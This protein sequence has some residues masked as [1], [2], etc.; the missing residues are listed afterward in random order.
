M[1][2]VISQCRPLP[3]LLALQLGEHT[4]PN[5]G[6]QAL[7]HAPPGALRLPGPGVTMEAVGAA[8]TSRFERVAEALARKQQSGPRF[9]AD[10]IAAFLVKEMSYGN[11]SLDWLRRLDGFP[12]KDCRL[13][14][15]YATRTMKPEIQYSAFHRILALCAVYPDLAQEFRNSQYLSEFKTKDTVFSAWDRSEDPACDYRWHFICELAAAALTDDVIPSLVHRRSRDELCFGVIEGTTV[16]EHLLNISATADATMSSHLA[17]R[18]LCTILA[19]P[20]FWA[21]LE[22]PF[23]RHHQDKRDQSRQHVIAR[24]FDRAKLLLQDAGF[25]EALDI[26]VPSTAPIPVDEEAID[27]FCMVLLDGFASYLRTHLPLHGMEAMMKHEVWYGGLNCV[28]QLL[29]WYLQSSPASDQRLTISR[30]EKFAACLVKP[31]CRWSASC[32]VRSIL[33]LTLKESWW[34]KLGDPVL[35]HFALYSVS[36]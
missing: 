29:R 22:I 33:L 11:P 19:W 35:S 5:P 26:M 7:L 34:G 27:K 25:D 10:R 13:L 32:A 18:H 1:M 4:C 17:L 30:S 2:T 36:G 21:R 31:I 15:K 8:L 23:D 3:P 12:A 24:L 9:S 28:L 16:L 6:S 14:V 20:N